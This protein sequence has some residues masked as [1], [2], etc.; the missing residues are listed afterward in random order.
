MKDNEL[1]YNEDGNIR[2]AWDR[3]MYYIAVNGKDGASKDVLDTMEDEDWKTV[4]SYKKMVEDSKKRGVVP[5]WGWSWE[6]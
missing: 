5:Q 6:G 3:T 2:A 1:K 4:E